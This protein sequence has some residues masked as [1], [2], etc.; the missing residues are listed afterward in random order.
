MKIPDLS[1]LQMLVLESLGPQKRSGR[2]LRQRLAQSGIKRSGP[3][4]YQ[5]MARLEEAGLVEGEY[6]QKIVEGQIIKE[7]WY[8]VT[9]EGARA[10][11]HTRDFYSRWLPAVAGLHLARD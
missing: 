3:A 2:D 1:H 6:S 8:R 5:L 7:R 9:G 4:F 10:A 11:R